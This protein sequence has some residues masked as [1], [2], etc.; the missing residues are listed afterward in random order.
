MGVPAV[1]R[2]PTKGCAKVSPTTSPRCSWCDATAFVMIS[3]SV[4]SVHPLPMA[5]ASMRSYV[6][7]CREK[8]KMHEKAPILAPLA[9]QF[10]LRELNLY[11][12]EAFG[13]YGPL[14]RYSRS[15]A[16]WHLSLFGSS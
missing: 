11:F 16:L 3:T 8:C 14:T 9:A 13:P 5:L 6:N 4:A 7:A 15:Y 12:A 2:V 1:L 10:T